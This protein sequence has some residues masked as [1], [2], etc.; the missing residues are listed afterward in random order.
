MTKQQTLELL[1]KQMPSFYSLEQVKQIVSDISDG[2]KTIDNDA[3]DELS[4][5]IAQRVCKLNLLAVYDYDLMVEGK[6]I[7]LDTITL[8]E[9]HIAEAAYEAIKDWQKG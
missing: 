2:Q 6:T 8:D 1:D 4:E 7:Y 9:A 5:K 3:L